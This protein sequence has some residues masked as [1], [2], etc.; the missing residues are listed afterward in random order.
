MSAGSYIRP[1][2]NR[3]Y[4]LKSSYLLIDGFYVVTDHPS[5]IKILK[6]S[7]KG[8]LVFILLT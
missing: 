2:V 6:E 7:S 8:V 1:F 5:M 3:V 4:I